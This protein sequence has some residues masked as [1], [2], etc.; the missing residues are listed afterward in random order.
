ML[1][2]KVKSEG[3]SHCTITDKVLYLV[4]DNNEI[5]ITFNISNLLKYVLSVPVYFKN[6]IEKEYAT[7]A[8]I[9]DSASVNLR[10]VSE[11]EDE[12]DDYPEDD[13]FDEE[14]IEE[15][16][17]TSSQSNDINKLV[18]PD[19][20]V[21]VTG[22]D[23]MYRGESPI[24]LA[25]FPLTTKQSMEIYLIQIGDTQYY[26]IKIHNT[27]RIL[28]DLLASPNDIL[29]VDIDKDEIY[30]LEQHH[31]VLKFNEKEKVLAKGGFKQAD[32]L[33]LKNKITAEMCKQ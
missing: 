33:D 22:R 20:A 10:L 7:K 25:N 6:M 17:D 31:C 18:E 26:N 19:D 21:P 9:L 30:T 13:D 12:Y 24:L 8:F 16:I 32:L 11:P 28:F 4:D 1:L 15:S 27:T 5:I 29:F 3:I 23:D 2:I 14:S